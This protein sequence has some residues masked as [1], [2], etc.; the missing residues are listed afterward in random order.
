MIALQETPLY[1][2]RCACSSIYFSEE[3]ETEQ[4]EWNPSIVIDTYSHTPPLSNAAMKAASKISGFRNF[5][6]NWDSYGAEKPSENAIAN[7]LS[8]IR[9]IDAH[10]IP[11]YFTAPRPNAALVVYPRQGHR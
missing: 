2:K 7:A 3:F 5:A 4:Q 9:I 6:D 11:V 10:G 8:F 1:R